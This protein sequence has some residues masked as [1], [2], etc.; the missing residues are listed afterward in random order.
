MPAEAG[1]GGASRSLAPE[2]GRDRF[3]GLLRQAIAEGATDLHLEPRDDGLEVRLRIDGRL[4]HR[5]FVDAGSKEG[6]I[7]AAKIA[8]RMDIAERRLPQDG[9][10]R[11]AVGAR[12]FDLRFSCLPAVN[13]EA[14]VVRLF[15]ELEKARPLDDGAL[16]PAD[17]G[18][19]RQL[20][21]LPHGLIYVTGPTGAGKTTLLHSMLA[22]LAEKDPG[23]LKMLTLEEPV[24]LRQPRILL[25]LEVDERIGRTFGE[26]LRH[27]LRHDPDVLLVGETRDAVTAATTLKAALT[28]HLC[29]STLHANDA[30]GAMARLADLGLDPVMLSCALKGLVAQRLVR[31]PC[32]RC[33]K[34]HPQAA[35]L[36]ERFRDLLAGE[37]VRPEGAEFLAAVPGRACPLCRG[38]GYRGRIP[39]VEVFPLLG[40]EP[41][42]ARR[43]PA[44][45]FLPRL[46]ALGCRTLF[47]D[48]VR[49]AAGGLTTI[50]EV[51]GALPEAAPGAGAPTAV[52]GPATISA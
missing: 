7:Q 48:G 3:Q 22:S 16:F 27:A 36:R 35:V 18:H 23:E 9:R 28:G 4:V 49:K 19:L 51:F 11:A 24:E 37:P 44:A 5:Q 13:G 42:V 34:P 30:L 6:L 10:G 15:D 52:E 12:R 33:R 26:L 41:L 43:A 1:D 14:V 50:E 20:L 38:R 8:G 31:T 40:L 32:P 47:E 25:Q 17:L 29:L 39:V 21:E 2:S 46:R 45:E